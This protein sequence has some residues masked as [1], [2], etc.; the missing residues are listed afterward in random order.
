[1]DGYVAY[2]SGAVNPVDVN[3]TGFDKGGDVPTIGSVFNLSVSKD[4]EMSIAVVLNANKNFYI[5]EDGVALTNYNG[6]KVADKY[7]GTY[8]FDVKAGKTYTTF[9]TGSKLGFYGFTFTAGRD[10]GI[11]YSTI[12]KE[13][14][15][16]EYYNI[17]GVRTN[18]PTKGLNMVKSTMSDG[19]VSV[20]KV[21]IP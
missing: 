3:N 19:S 21:Y 18:E 13:V 20:E 5:L 9:C 2:V 1:M 16:T 4:G 6:I 8:E 15:S 10:T 14:V 17:V 12:N 7:Y 11:T